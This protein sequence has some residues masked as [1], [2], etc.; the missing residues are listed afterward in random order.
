MAGH[1]F[2]PLARPAPQITT[3]IPPHGPTE[4]QRL[5]PTTPQGRLPQEKHCQPG[6]V[7]VYP[8]AFGGPRQSSQEIS[9]E[10]LDR[11]ARRKRFRSAGCAPRRAAVTSRHKEIRSEGGKKTGRISCEKR[12]TG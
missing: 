9:S 4:T 5:R 1:D 2:T 12:R 6:N 8:N 7:S 10:M 3:S 11:P